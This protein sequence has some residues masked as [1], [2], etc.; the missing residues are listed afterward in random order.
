MTI[1]TNCT[2]GCPDGHGQHLCGCHTY[3]S[4]YMMMLREEYASQM[5]KITRRLNRL[6]NGEIPPSQH[7]GYAGTLRLQI[8]ELGRIVAR[9]AVEDHRNDSGCH[10]DEPWK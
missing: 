1:Q 6:K 5:D 7:S 8:V 2:C 10:N 9:M 3:D 4:Q